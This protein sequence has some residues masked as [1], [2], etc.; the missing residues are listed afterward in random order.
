MFVHRFTIP[1]I[2]D[3]AM[4]G[5]YDEK[6]AIRVDEHDR[7]VVERLHASAGTDTKAMR[8]ADEP[9]LHARP[10]AGDADRERT[11]AQEAGLETRADRD[12]P[13]AWALGTVT[14]GPP[15]RDDARHSWPPRALADEMQTTTAV[16]AEP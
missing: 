10:P 3:L 15:D 8:D 4:P 1:Y 9:R 16:R 6:R 2:D 7:P 5:R 13:D 11:T 12:R 14:F